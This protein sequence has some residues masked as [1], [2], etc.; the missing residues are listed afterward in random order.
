MIAARGGSLVKY[1]ILCRAEYRDAVAICVT[2]QAPL[3]R[4]LDSKEAHANPAR[5]LWTG[6][7]PDE[8]EVVDRALRDAEIPAFVEERLAGLLGGLVR[9]GS[10]IHVL[11]EDFDRA[12]SAAASAIQSDGRV[13][14]PQQACYSCARQCSAFL[15]ACPFCKATL[16]VEQKKAPDLQRSTHPEER[17]IMKY[18]PLCDAEYS[19]VHARCTVCG[20]E[21]VPEE[22]RGRPLDERQ[23][24]ERIEL[25]WRGGDPGAV[26][27]VIHTLR[28]AGIRHHVQ[29]TNDHLV[30]ELGM[31]RP[32]YAVRTFASDTAKAKELLASIH[33]PSPFVS[34]EASALA[35]ADE[36]VEQQPSRKHDWRPAAAT[37]EIWT[38]AD[39][40][41]AQLLQDCLR[42][43]G[44]AV[45][46]QGRPPGII[47][48]R[49]MPAD[50]AAAREIIREV[51]E[52]TPP[53]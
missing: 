1:C 31:P 46:C 29:A 41:L 32:K 28:E 7:D 20:V 6:K 22:L 4:S 40:A 35:L 49:V 24:K 36:P 17:S 38:G 45:R 50:E 25:V 44:I 51:R 9:S 14:N 21:L 18:C 15:A 30:F 2:C 34:M 5:L 26:S 27:Q 43:N 42:E 52:A 16:I 53:A 10:H 13:Y 47:L 3:V 8:F 19:G 37:L 12:L 48:L 33:E 39:A 23:R 11:S